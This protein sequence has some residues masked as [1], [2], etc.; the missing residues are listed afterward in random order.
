G[1][2]D[3][4]QLSSSQR[5]SDQHARQQISHELGHERLKVT[6]IYLGT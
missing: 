6:S 3:K 2:P 5:M 4:A 1:G